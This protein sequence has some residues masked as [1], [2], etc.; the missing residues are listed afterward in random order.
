MFS[1]NG[2]EVSFF[3]D[4]KTGNMDARAVTSG[5]YMMGLKI[6]G[7]NDVDGTNPLP[8]YIGE[9]V[10]MAKRCGEHLYTLSKTPAYFGLTPENMTDN[11][12]VLCFDVLVSMPDNN[13]RW[14][15]ERRSK[16]KAIIMDSNT[17][18][19]L[20]TSDRQFSKF[21]DRVKNVQ[22]KINELRD[23]V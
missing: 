7:I 19:Q 15:R 14:D 11:D 4:C 17:L 2:I 18:T 22:A 16:E 20:P 8:L 10:Y 3:K 13:K 12:L 23:S 21:E 1:D 9:S 6:K 5:V